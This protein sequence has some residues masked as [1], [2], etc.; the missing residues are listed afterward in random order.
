M[1]R[2]A[3]N[4]LPV[5]GFTPGFDPLD[6]L[7]CLVGSSLAFIRS[8]AETAEWCNFA[9]EVIARGCP[10]HSR[11]HY[12]TLCLV[13]PI[14]QGPAPSPRCRGRRCA[15]PMATGLNRSS[16]RWLASFVHDPMLLF[17]WIH[18]V[19]ETDGQLPSRTCSVSAPIPLLGSQPSFQRLFWWGSHAFRSTS[20]SAQRELELIPENPHRTSLEKRWPAVL[21][22]HGSIIEA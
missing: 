6:P 13:A 19:L 8:S 17:N 20:P 11:P 10:S 14:P 18:L 22:C 21:F 7:G 1:R 3:P 5:Q 16:G 2:N 15:Y 9:V 4:L 12:D